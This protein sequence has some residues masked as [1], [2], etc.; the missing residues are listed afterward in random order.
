MTAPAEAPGAGARLAILGAMLLCT[1]RWLEIIVPYTPKVVE[2][3][4]GGVTLL[5]VAGHV[6]IENQPDEKRPVDLLNLFEHVGVGDLNFHP[7]VLLP[8]DEDGFGKA[9]GGG[10][11]R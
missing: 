3:P 10:R 2:Q 6:T 7:E 9:K 11:R 1:L 4:C 5:H 8:I